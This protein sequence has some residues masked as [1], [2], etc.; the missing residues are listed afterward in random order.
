MNQAVKNAIRLSQT[1]LRKQNIQLQLELAENIP[2]F[3]GN[4]QNIEQVILNLLINA[5]QSVE[6]N[7]G[8]IGIATTCPKNDHIVMTVSDN[9]RGISSKIANQLFDP[10]VTDRQAHGG[11]GLGLSVSYN[12]I[13]AH[14]GTIRFKSQEGVGTTFQIILPTD[15]RKKIQRILI[16]DDDPLIRELLRDILM[17]RRAYSI[18]EASNGIEACIRL[19]SHR[20]DL[21]VLDLFMPEM[22]GLDVCRVIRNDIEF[23]DLKLM[24]ITGHEGHADLEE[25]SRMRM[26]EILYKPFNLIDFLKKVD[27]IL[28]E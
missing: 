2:L 21:M 20:P 8:R 26:V 22:N 1:T 12:I 4:Q 10:F 13:A 6:H 18:E 7:H 25:I 17:S 9:G 5:A 24:V 16:V 3:V 28:A 15:S 19:G 27:N 14:E 11:T 23:S